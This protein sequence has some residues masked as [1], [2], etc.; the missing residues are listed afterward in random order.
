M[1]FVFFS[2]VNSKKSQWIFCSKMQNFFKIIVEA[3]KEIQSKNFGPYNTFVIKHLQDQYI[4]D[5]FDVEVINYLKHL[6]YYE[7]NCIA[8]YLVATYCYDDY[9]D[10]E[11]FKFL[12]LSYKNK[13]YLAYNALA[14]FYL[15]NDSMERY[16]FIKNEQ[17]LNYEGHRSLPQF[18]KYNLYYTKN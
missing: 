3:N 10:I 13:Y 9:Y 5:N 4:Y 7:N 18:S 17:D 1:E 2:T 11:A 15:E 6:A 8:Q 16:L 12:T 14:D